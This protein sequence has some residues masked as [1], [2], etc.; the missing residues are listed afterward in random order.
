[1]LEFRKTVRADYPDVITDDAGFVTDLLR[2]ELPGH[3][4]VYACGPPPM[5][6]AVRALAADNAVPAQ[7]A[8]GRSRAEA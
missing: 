3:V 8:P 7:L 5:L 2:H 6:E 1:M 4:E